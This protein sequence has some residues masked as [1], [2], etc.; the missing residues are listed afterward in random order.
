MKRLLPLLVLAAC[1]TRAEH[2]VTMKAMSFDPPELTIA[3]GDLVVWKNGDLVAHT[4][5]A[6]G[7]FDS[8]PVQ[9]DASF[10]VTVSKPGE[11]VYRCTLHPTM[12][13]KLIVK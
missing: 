1:S 2:V 7:R 13:G 8:G 6:A 11:V 3:A 9:P 5:T 12:V 10:R 4:A